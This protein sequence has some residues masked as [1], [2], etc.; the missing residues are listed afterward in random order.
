MT[1]K[2][3]FV[4]L[5]IALLVTPGLAAT[6]SVHSA[7][8]YV[9][10]APKEV[11]VILDS[12]PG[13]LSGYDITL[14]V[15]DPSLATIAAASKPGWA[16]IGTVGSTPAGSIQITGADI[17][18]QVQSGAA[19]VTLGTVAIQALDVGTVT[20]TITVTALDDDTGTPIEATTQS[21]TITLFDGLR[22]KASATIA[23]VDE[24]GYD[25]LMA[26][27]GGDQQ[28]NETTEGVDWLGIKAAAEAP[29]TATTGALFFAIIFSLPFIMQWL[30][31]GNMAI[32]SVVGIILGGIMLMKAPA[33][34]HLAAVAF[35]A[36]AVLGVVWGVI[37]DRV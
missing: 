18:D 8:A 13:G 16:T 5:L 6:I 24:S 29:Y 32:P 20:L 27:I 23:T 37:K 14:S 1:R 17:N 28:L 30:R 22:P 35:I 9:G 19:G 3:L 33:E 31:Q 2:L 4:A 25:L 34:Y 10:Q 11:N 15:S 12:A 7:T 21:A 26:S 36:L